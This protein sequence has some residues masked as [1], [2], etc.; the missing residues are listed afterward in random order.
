LREGVS[1][2]AAMGVLDTRQGDGTYVT[3]LEPGLL[4]A[5]MSFAVAVHSATR[6]GQFSAVRRVLE[7]E[8]AALAAVSIEA[9][10]LAVLEESVAESEAAAHAPA[11]V[12]RLLAADVT[13][14]R[15]VAAGAGNPVLAV[16]IESM[17]GR[18]TRA[19]GRD[20]V[21]RDEATL[22]RT[23]TEHRAV[24]YAITGHDPEQAR[25]RMGAH[26]GH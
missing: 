18:S 12:A 2:L 10:V 7:G 1:A 3:S 16:L 26:L 24:L 15:A 8:A 25:R 13:F 19:P 23:V 21:V 4:M 5:S 11:D 6:P 9:D 17:S 14:H 22:T 20:V